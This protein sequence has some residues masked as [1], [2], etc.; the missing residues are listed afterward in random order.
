MADFA[1]DSKNYSV[2]IT[3]LDVALKYM[4][5]EERL[6][7]LERC[8]R[9]PFEKAIGKIPYSKKLEKTNAVITNGMYLKPTA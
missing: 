1:K 8:Y 4:E 2:P 3:A 6:V 9:R 5:L 7:G